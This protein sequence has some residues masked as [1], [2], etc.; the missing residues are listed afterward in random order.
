[1]KTILAQMETDFLLVAA[2]GEKLPLQVVAGAA[3]LAGL[4]A[5]MT[6]LMGQQTPV[7]EVVEQEKVII[8]ILALVVRVALV[9]SLSGGKILINKWHT[10]QKL[11]VKA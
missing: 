6:G 5:Q 8:T 3:V 4:P 9:R 7:V 10:L 1:M 11:I 2:V